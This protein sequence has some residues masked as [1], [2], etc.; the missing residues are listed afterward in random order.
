MRQL[1]S[2]ARGERLADPARLAVPVAVG[3]DT[4][5]AARIRRGEILAPDDDTA[6]D[7]YLAADEVLSGAGCGWY[8]D[9]PVA[10]VA[11]GGPA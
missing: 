8:E 2:R 5:L 6:A 9:V 7:R 4:R 10:R 3:G 11:A 1:P